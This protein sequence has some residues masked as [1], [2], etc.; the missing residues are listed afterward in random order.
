MVSGIGSL[1]LHGAGDGN[2]DLLGRGH[3]AP[4]RGAGRQGR[5]GHGKARQ[6]NAAGQCKAMQFKAA[7]KAQ[8]SSCLRAVCDGRSTDRSKCLER[9]VLQIQLFSTGSSKDPNI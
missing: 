9:A 5:A 8:A 2:D 3:G 6:G 4:L 1:L 7:M